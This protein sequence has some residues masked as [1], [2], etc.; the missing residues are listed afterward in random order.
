MDTA[1]PCVRNNA[2]EFND[3]IEE[4]KNIRFKYQKKM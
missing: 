4:Y 3:E 2:D 1:A